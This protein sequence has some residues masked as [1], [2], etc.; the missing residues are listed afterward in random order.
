MSLVAE[1]LMK[2]Y[3]GRRVVDGVDL[4]VER[5]EIVGLLGP[6]RSSACWAPTGRA[7]P[8]AST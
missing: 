3:G 7:R 2:S 4:R 8:P 1:G 6:K 5:G